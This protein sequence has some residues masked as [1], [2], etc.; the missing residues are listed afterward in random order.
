MVPQRAIHT[1]IQSNGTLGYNHNNV[2]CFIVIISMVG[3]GLQRKRVP[4]LAREL[5]DNV[6]KYATAL[7]V[8]VKEIVEEFW[9]QQY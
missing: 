3:L 1:V 6:I 9:P 7:L 5:P 4:N 2:E 8:E